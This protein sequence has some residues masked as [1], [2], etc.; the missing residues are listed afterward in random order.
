VEGGGG[1]RWRATVATI[2]GGGGGRRHEEFVT[3]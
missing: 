3:P 1:L 2:E